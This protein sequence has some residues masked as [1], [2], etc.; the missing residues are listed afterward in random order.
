MFLNFDITLAAIG[1][2]VLV[3]G[4]F[5]AGVTM[6]VDGFDRSIRL[7]RIADISLVSACLGVAIAVYAFIAPIIATHIY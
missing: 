3:T 2:I 4:C 6:E 7:K 1:V 5:A